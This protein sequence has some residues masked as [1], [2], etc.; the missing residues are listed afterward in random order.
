MIIPVRMGSTRFANK[1]LAIVGGKP[2]LANVIE[3]ALKAKPRKVVVASD[4]AP[5]LT[6]IAQ[7]CGV[8]RVVASGNFDCGSQRVA[9]AYE[10]L[11][12]AEPSLAGEVVVNL[13]GDIPYFPKEA[14]ELVAGLLE[15]D[16]ASKGNGPGNG[17]SKGAAQGGDKSNGASSGTN[18]ATDKATSTAPTTGATN[19]APEGIEMATLVSP[20]GTTEQVTNPNAVKAKVEWHSPTTGSKARGKAVEFS[21]HPV[22]SS[23]G[24]FYLHHGI[25]GFTPLALRQF[26]V[27]SPSPREKLEHLE[28]LRALGARIPIWV[29][30]IETGFGS[31]DS[32]EDIASLEKGKEHK[33]R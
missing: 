3:S 15:R 30:K 16:G 4:G 33:S 10:K 9:Y 29:A 2:L 11:V 28:Q 26:A 8:E 7:E 32:T 12:K 19:T 5:Q 1:P 21:R 6:Q 17:G 13:Q 14:L 23:D 18:K 24:K 20:F 27:L 22:K 25:Y 31:V